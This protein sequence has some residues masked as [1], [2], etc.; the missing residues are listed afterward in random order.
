MR[1]DTLIL[2][3]DR[4]PWDRERE[5]LLARPITYG[6]AQMMAT[7][8]FTCWAADKDVVTYDEYNRLTG[9]VIRNCRTHHGRFN[10]EGLDDRQILRSS[11]RLVRYLSSQL[12]GWSFVTRFPGVFAMSVDSR[13]PLERVMD[14]ADQSPVA[15][16]ILL[17]GELPLQEVDR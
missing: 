15:F 5:I 12:I 9:V 14:I 11:G 10:V 6:Y 8:F 13:L 7:P 4:C 17:L 1:H 16:R 2:Y 3:G